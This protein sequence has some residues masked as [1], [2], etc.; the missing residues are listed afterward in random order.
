MNEHQYMSE[1]ERQILEMGVSAR[2][3]GQAKSPPSEFDMRLR[4][5]W[6]AGWNERD[7]ELDCDKSRE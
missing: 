7:Q 4:H 5:W 2:D 6:L 3:S 1:R